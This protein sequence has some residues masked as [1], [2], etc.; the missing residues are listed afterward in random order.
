MLGRIRL[1]WTLNSLIIRVLGGAS[2]PA[3]G[4]GGQTALTAGR[5]S[6]FST[7]A[8]MRRGLLRHLPARERG[9]HHR[10]PA[11][12]SGVEGRGG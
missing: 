11:A 5:C 7:R 12:G 9:R 2:A 6:L 3:G 10:P 4:G 1:T 8:G